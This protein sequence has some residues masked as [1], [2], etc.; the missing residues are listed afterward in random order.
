[1]R[2]N[3]SGSDF[4]LTEL[5][6][7][8]DPLWGIYYNGWDNSGAAVSSAVGIHHP[9]G[10]IKKISIENDPLISSAWGGTPANSHW[11]NPNWDFGVTEG[12]SSGSPLF[13]QNHRTIG[14]L[15]GGASACGNSA[16]NMW[17]DYGKFSFSWTGNNTDATRLSNWL[18][19][20]G[21][22]ATS[23]DGVDPAGPGAVI[24]GSIGNPQGVSGVFCGASVIPQVTI[25]NSGSDP[26][27]SCTIN[28][29]YDALLNQ[30]YP[31]TGNLAQYQTATIT[32]P[33][34]TLSGGNHTFNAELANPNGLTDENLNN[35]T[36]ASSFTTVVNGQSVILDL[37]LDCWASE[38]SWE[39]TDGI[40]T[41][42]YSGSGYSDANP[43]TVSTE[44]CLAEGCYNF[45]IMDSFE[46]GMSGCSTSSGGN[47]SYQI[48]YNSDV[49]A[50][51]VEADANFGPFNIKNF[52]ISVN[53]LNEKDLATQVSV[54]PNPAS[55]D[56]AVVSNGILIQKVELLNLAGQVIRTINSND[57][58]V[59]LDVNSV[60]SGVYLVKIFSAEG[61]TT[62]QL[63]IK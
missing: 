11:R 54:Y 37:N 46:D 53:S 58:V 7:A 29:G 28:Y 47:G 15:H 44:F 4:T 27:T 31:W 33:A 19:P 51:I 50:E 63:I 8:P 41:L 12:G 59:K 39:L 23:I 16:T 3:W 21:T 22:G 32:L 49:V 48:T 57:Q 62:K 38:T 35:N 45:K 25:T 43:I 30:S 26:L 2:A 13:D 61:S 17:D 18:D 5:N 10:D 24:D 55:A 36:I 56:F 52:C 20:A 1:L 9:R 34:A 42:L 40:G 60:S 14:Q 6:S